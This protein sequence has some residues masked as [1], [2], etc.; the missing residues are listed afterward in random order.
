[1]ASGHVVEPGLHL[2]EDTFV[3][4]A[5]QALMLVGRA[6][7]LERAGRT[8]GEVAVMIDIVLSV[9]THLSPR[10]VLVRSERHRIPFRLVRPTDHE[11]DRLFQHCDEVGERG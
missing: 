10:Q 3:F 4:P 1:M 6:P 5:L 2:V 11:T 7:G 9:R 8:G